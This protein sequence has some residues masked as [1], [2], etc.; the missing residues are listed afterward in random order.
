MEYL[1]FETSNLLYYTIDFIIVLALIAGFRFFSSLIAN[2]SLTD[3]LSE[4]DN[5]A[6]GIS[7]SGALIGIA[8][9]LT[10][11]MSGEVASSPQQ[12]AIMIASYGG[13]GIILMGLTRLLLDYVS[14]SKI[15]IKQL[16][17]DGNIAAGLVD[18]GNMIASALMVRA[19][20]LWVE[21]DTLIGL[22]VIL[23]GFV[24]SQVLLYLATQ[25]RRFIFQRC[26]PK[27]SLQAEIAACNVA[28]AVRFSGYRIA[29]ALAITTASG[30]V[31]FQADQM[32][33]SVGIWFVT[34]LVLFVALTLVAILVRWVLLPNINVACEVTEQANVA[35]GSLEAAIYISVGLVFLGLLG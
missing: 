11:V 15:S 29:I 23:L 2:G 20:M 34:A 14:L 8:I 7:M 19:I 18:A 10:G 4:Q 21:V 28:L 6:M 5:F 9:M 13:L 3:V 32:W 12:E 22:S 26:H 16:I 17:Q 30:F 35:I 27:R 31:I 1:S 33:L 24:A 25:Y